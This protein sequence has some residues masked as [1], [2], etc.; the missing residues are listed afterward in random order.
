MPFAESARRD[1]REYTCTLFRFHCTKMNAE[2]S[3]IHVCITCMCFQ[4]FQIYSVSCRPTTSGNPCD[5]PTWQAYTRTTPR[6]QFRKFFGLRVCYIRST[7]QVSESDILMGRK[8]T[9]SFLKA[10][11]FAA[12]MSLK[13]FSEPPLNFTGVKSGRFYAI[14]DPS[15]SCCRLH[16]SLK[17][18]TQKRETSMIYWLLGCST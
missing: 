3:Y 10:L 6:Q 1:F 5:V 4:M 17:L 18:K 11:Y 15:S 12:V 8:V 16:F 13:H 7:L 14:F 2:V 9:P